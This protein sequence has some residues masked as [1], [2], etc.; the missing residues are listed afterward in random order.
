MQ[1]CVRLRGKK[2]GPSH[3][4]TQSSVTTLLSWQAECR[5]VEV[6]SSR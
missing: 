2:L 6:D 5:V 4:H 1:D 3:P